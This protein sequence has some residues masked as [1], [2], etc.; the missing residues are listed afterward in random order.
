MCRYHLPAG[1]FS[2]NGLLDS[3][4]LAHVYMHMPEHTWHIAA[5]ATIHTFPAVLGMRL[6][7]WLK[8]S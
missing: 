3:V 5:Q 4:A 1:G 8:G 6:S 2:G 7:M